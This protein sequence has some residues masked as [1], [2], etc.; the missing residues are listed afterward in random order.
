MLGLRR[1]QAPDEDPDRSDYGQRV[2]RILQAF[3]TPL[4]G[5]PPPF[6]GAVTAA[7]RE[8]A[9]AHLERLAEA[10]FAPDL[11]RRALAHVWLTEFRACIPAVVDW[12]SE[13]DAVQV[14][15]ETVLEQA[16]TPGLRLEG[17]ADRL[18]TY[19]D[20][21]K[22]VVDYKTGSRVPKPVEVES[23][24]AVQLVH[25][26]LLDAAITRVE[27]LWLKDPREKLAIDDAL[28][29]LRDAVAERLHALVQAMGRGDGLPA[30]GDDAT[31]ARC[32]YRGLCRKGDWTHA[33]PHARLVRLHPQDATPEPGE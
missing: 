13:R 21:G 10:V 7:S 29:E 17:R 9:V 20:G 3:V 25:Y 6:A 28:P 27:Y 30:R 4:A 23:G 16:F 12:L 31:C 32:E 33:Q 11:Q 22:G 15:T 26:A 1:E 5:L 2:H 24:E 18:E 19:A 8:A 14:Q